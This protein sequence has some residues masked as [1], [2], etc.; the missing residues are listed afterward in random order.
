MKGIKVKG[1]GFNPYDEVKF[2]AALFLSV[3][4]ILYNLENAS[5]LENSNKMFIC[6]NYTN[7]VYFLDD[8]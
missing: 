7:L 1:S 3:E 8:S 2:T 5:S 4:S 6:T